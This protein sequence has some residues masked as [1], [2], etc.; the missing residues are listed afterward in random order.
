M[1]KFCGIKVSAFRLN[2]IPQKT[3]FAYNGKRLQAAIKSG[4]FIGLI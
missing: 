2:L 1:G 4:Y 3:P